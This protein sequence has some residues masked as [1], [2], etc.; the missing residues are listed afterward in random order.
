MSNSGTPDMILRN[1][2]L[3]VAVSSMGGAIV[4][5][6]HCSAAIN[7]LNFFYDEP[8][9]HRR[10]FCGHF[11]CMPR[12]GDVSPAEHKKG[13]VK[14]GDFR[15]LEWHT[16]VHTGNRLTMQVYSEAEQWSVK[17][18]LQLAQQSPVF[19]VQETVVNHSNSRRAYNIVQHPTIAAP[20]LHAGTRID[21]NGIGGWRDQGIG[22][23]PALSGAWP[24]LTNQNGN[25]AHL[26]LPTPA[27]AGVYSF[28]VANTSAGWI[29]AYDPR[30]SLLLGYTWPAQDYPFIHH[31]IHAENNRI[32][33]RGL[34]FGT[35]AMHQPFS[36]QQEND[37]CWQQQ[38]TCRFL[39]AGGT[40]TFRYYGFLLHT[41]SGMSGIR[42]IQYDENFIYLYPESNE[43][44]YS[45][46]IR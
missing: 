41:D 33:Y 17:R 8:G 34:E 29:T 28:P 31:W 26:G 44:I 22:K 6:Q 37:F 12:W 2:Q 4:S 40:A 14:H 19:C 11:I 3:T 13:L 16:D 10:S 7:P 30:S 25:S 35:A 43:T 15:S 36:L 46:S 24:R 9:P 42:Q 45:L 32:T 20:F 21:C 18:T 27:D 1:E 23:L 5:L 39:D 38:P